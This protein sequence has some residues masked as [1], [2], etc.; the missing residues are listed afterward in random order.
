MTPYEIVVII[1]SGL[2]LVG[3]IVGAYAD[4]RQ[5]ISKVSAQYN[6]CQAMH[7]QKIR[8]L[9]SEIDRNRQE[10]IDQLKAIN[11]KLTSLD[12]NMSSIK[13]SIAKIQKNGNNS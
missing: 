11:L 7:S 5:R 6:T 4:L 8:Y 2:A 9:E 12:A 10:Y 1:I 13:I 3:S